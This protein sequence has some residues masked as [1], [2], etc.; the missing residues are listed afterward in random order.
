MSSPYQPLDL[1]DL[2]PTASDPI[3]N[4]YT[5]DLAIALQRAN[6]LGLGVQM[7]PKELMPGGRRGQS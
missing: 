7:P 5:Q 3:V 6:S 4:R 2:E 1:M